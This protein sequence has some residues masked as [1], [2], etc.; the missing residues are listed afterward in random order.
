M[1]KNDDVTYGIYF[2]IYSKGSH[3]FLYNL[4]IVAAHG[5]IYVFIQ[6]WNKRVESFHPDTKQR[7][8]RV[9]LCGSGK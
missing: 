7:R 1:D 4:N 3:F 5:G 2:V 9:K 6:V 8:T